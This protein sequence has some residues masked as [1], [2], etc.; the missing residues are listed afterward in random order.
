MLTDR[1]KS[2]REMQLE[3][4]LRDTKEGAVR[5]YESR[6]AKYLDIANRVHIESFG[7]KLSEMK[8]YNFLQKMANLENDF[9]SKGAGEEV[10]KILFTEAD[11]TTT[12][13]TIG[14]FINH[15]F[16]VVTAQTPINIME[17]F[18][19]IQTVDQRTAEVF[20]FNIV[21]GSDKGS[22]H[23]QGDSYMGA[24]TGA[25]GTK[26]GKYTT[27]YID[28]EQ[29]GISDGSTNSYHSFLAWKP[30]IPSAVVITFTI[31]GVAYTTTDDGSGSFPVDTYVNAG[32]SVNYTTGELTI[33]FKPAGYADVGSIVY[34][35]YQ[36]NSAVYGGQIPKVYAEL[37]SIMIPTQRQIV[38]GSYLFDASIMLKKEKGLDL[39]K[40]MVEQVI[41]G[42]MNDNAVRVANEIYT[43]A[44]GGSKTIT[45]DT[46]APSLNIPYI[47]HRME[48]LGLLAKGELDI[49]TE[50]RYAVASYV[51]GGRD[52]VSV[53][54]GLP[55]DFYKPAKYDKKPAGMHVA[56]VLD[57]KFDIIQNLDMQ[58]DAFVLGAM[59]E[60]LHTGSMFVEFIPIT[61]MDSFSD[62]S[63]DIYKNIVAWNGFKILN[64]KFFLQGK[65]LHG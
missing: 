47:Q 10:D 21:K 40:T 50:I 6:Y 32:S 1:K 38:Q 44:V 52:F 26:D 22:L 13:T 9:R 34:S 33:N 62:R 31:A 3:S 43:S 53:C 14:K 51:I 37:T 65:I 18:T 23:V 16:G 19:Q 30:L 39:E 48:I 63:A 7:T 5:N 8:T 36:Y 28:L 20:Y 25:L 45:F 17:K 49:Q 55:R 15:S 27:K 54:A 35:S 61:V 57:E 2:D 24:I 46:V 58:R 42:M 29:V 64:N 56:G 11:V 41:A 4:R 59:G 60:E 12:P